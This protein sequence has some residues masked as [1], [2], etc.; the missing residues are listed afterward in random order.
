MSTLLL[1]IQ[2][3]GFD[4]FIIISYMVYIFAAFGVAF[5]SPKYITALD[6]WVKIY[7]CLF[8]LV[9]FNPFSG[10]IKF[11]DLDRKISFSSGI[12]LATSIIVNTILKSYIDKTST[13]ASNTISK[14]VY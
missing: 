7:I 11:T 12:L 8:L 5:I 6:F 4:L 1:K 9:R 14:I 2:E 3:R 13:T 10:K